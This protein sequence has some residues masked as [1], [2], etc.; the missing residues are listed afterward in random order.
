MLL[1]AARYGIAEGLRAGITTFADTCDSGV[2][3]DAMRERGVR[4]I[5][6][7][8]VFGPDPAQCAALARRAP[9]EGR[10]PAPPRDAT[11]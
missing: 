2:A 4:G 8:E 11:R 3:F 5:M 7:Q 9:R 6:Y 10:A 1:D